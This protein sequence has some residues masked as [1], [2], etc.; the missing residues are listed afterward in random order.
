MDALITYL[1]VDANIQSIFIT[2]LHQEKILA[3]LGIRLKQ[4]KTKDDSFHNWD[5]KHSEMLYIACISILLYI[6]FTLWAVNT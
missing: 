2:Y 3:F 1:S 4:V 6:P 5:R